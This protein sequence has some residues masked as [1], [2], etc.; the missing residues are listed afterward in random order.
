MSQKEYFYRKGKLREG[1]LVPQDSL[2]ILRHMLLTDICY[3]ATNCL[4]PGAETGFG[5]YCILRDKVFSMQSTTVS[6]TFL[7]YTNVVRGNFLQLPLKGGDGTKEADTLLIS[8][9]EATTQSGYSQNISFPISPIMRSLFLLLVFC[10]SSQAC[11]TSQDKPQTGNTHPQQQQQSSDPQQQQS[12]V[13]LQS[14]QQQFTNRLLQQIESNTTTNFVLSPHSIH[15]VFSQVLQGSGGRTKAELENLLGVTASDSL[16]EQYRILGEGLSGEGF[17]QTNLRW[18]NGD[19]NAMVLVNAVYF[20]ANWQIP[21][22]VRHTH[23]R[24]FN[25]PTGSKTAQFMTTIAKVR[26]LDDKERKLK[27]LELPYENPNRSMLIVLPDE[28]ISTENLAKRLEGLDFTSI[29]TNEEPIVTAI[30]IPKFELKFETDLK[31]Q[32]EQ[33]GVRDL[34]SQRSANLSGIRNERLFVSKG[35][36]QAVIEVNEEGTAAAAATAVV[37]STR[38]GFGRP[39]LFLADRPFLFI[40]FDFQHKTTLFAGK[41]VDPNNAKVVQTRAA[42]IQEPVIPASP[43]VAANYAVCNKMFRDFPNSLDNSVICNKVKSEGEKLGWFVGLVG[44]LRKNRALCKES[45][46]FIDIFISKSCGELWCDFAA[47]QLDD[48]S[49]EAAS[50][51]CQDIEGE[52]ESVETKRRCKTV[53]NKLKAAEF[54]QCTN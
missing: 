30:T 15:S 21:F 53:K 48:W 29:R 33:L 5:A 24:N 7:L 3:D 54:L 8:E 13:S 49:A 16:V 28:E 4:Y 35:V 44:W 36:H 47:P 25:S 12:I 51:D 43:A 46:D 50:S 37:V 45:K 39:R 20:K 1:P 11:K 14:G 52:Y 26:V 27:I 34:F 9:L 19:V 18:R 31:E 42:L 40:V 41:V 23:S 32:M 17:K 2:R 38:S 10:W 22:N 6:G